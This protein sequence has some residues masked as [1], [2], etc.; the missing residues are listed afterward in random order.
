MNFL[1]TDSRYKRIEKFNSYELT[2]CIIFEM[3]TRNK[4]VKELIKDITKY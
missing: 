2:H 1:R 4:N 3:A